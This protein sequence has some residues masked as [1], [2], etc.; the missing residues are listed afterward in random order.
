M[1][2]KTKKLIIGLGIGALGITLSIVAWKKWGKK[3][4]K[5]MMSQADADGL[6]K[7]YV[8]GR[9]ATKEQQATNNEITNKLSAGGYELKAGEN[10]AVYIAVKK[11][12]NM[13]AKVCWEHTGK[14]SHQVP[15]NDK[16]LS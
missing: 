11:S 15:C 7:K 14:G 4:D 1:E 5:P 9:G 12:S 2:A 6:A 10:S 3:L 8:V 13:T 16:D